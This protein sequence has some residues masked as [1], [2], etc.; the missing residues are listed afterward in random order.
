V[1]TPVSRAANDECSPANYDGIINYIII[2]V[3]VIKVS[4]NNK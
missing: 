2:G 4:R 3:K 1:Q